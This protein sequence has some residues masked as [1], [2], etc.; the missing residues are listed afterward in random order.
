MRIAAMLVPHLRHGGRGLWSDTAIP[1]MLAHN[2]RAS[3][4]PA[5]AIVRAVND[6]WDNDTT[7][8]IVGAVVGALH[9]S[10]DLP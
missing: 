4:D 1:A 10:R 9:G 8:A 3:T 2:D 7:G 6:T 5:E